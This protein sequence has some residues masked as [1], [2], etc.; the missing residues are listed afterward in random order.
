MKVD[1][2]NMMKKFLKIH[3]DLH[4]LDFIQVVRIFQDIAQKHRIHF[5]GNY[6]LLIVLIQKIVNIINNSSFKMIP[7]KVN[8]YDYNY[9]S[10]L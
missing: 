1:Q 4:N 2:I 3:L 6:W 8:D 7:A 5:L 10:F 9:Q